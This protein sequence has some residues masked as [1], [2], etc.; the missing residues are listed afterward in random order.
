MPL[1]LPSDVALVLVVIGRVLLGAFF[2][3]GGLSHFPELDPVSSAMKARGVPFARAT[4]IIGTIWQIL[5]G[6]ML[7]VGFYTT[8]AAL[9][10]ALFLI[11][12]TIMMLNFWDLPAGP[13]RDGAYR[14]FQSNVALL[15]GLLVAAAS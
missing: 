9:A 5:F 10:L 7:V 13:Q 3:I 6:A 8:I 15:G 11:L 14:G 2:I 12:A 1:G 4:L